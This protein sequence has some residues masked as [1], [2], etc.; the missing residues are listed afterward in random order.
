MAGGHTVRHSAL[1][2]LFCVLFP[3]FKLCLLE[4]PSIKSISSTTA[5]DT[6]MHK[7]KAS[8]LN[9]AYFVW[10]SRGGANWSAALQ[11]KIWSPFG[12]KNPVN[13][14]SYTHRWRCL[15]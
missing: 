15:S 7:I 2:V 12:S 10:G 1:L 4:V 8:K 5:L 3:I 14:H 11:S 6:G 9:A 13:H